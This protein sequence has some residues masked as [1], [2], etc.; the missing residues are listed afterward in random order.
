MLN[1]KLERILNVVREIEGRHVYQ[2]VLMETINIE[3]KFHRWRQEKRI[4][5][6]K[7]KREKEIREGKL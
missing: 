3:K 2:R 5:G 1:R 7:N 4:G 6:V